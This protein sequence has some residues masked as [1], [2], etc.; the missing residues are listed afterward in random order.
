MEI[1]GYTDV[2]DFTNAILEEAEVALVTGTGF[3]APVKIFVLASSDL[4][5]LKR[6]FVVS[7]LLWKNKYNIV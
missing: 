3:G 4:N 2:N 5:I 1:K 7:K 6:L